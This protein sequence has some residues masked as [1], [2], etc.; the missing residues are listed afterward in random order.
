MTYESQPAIRWKKNLSPK[1]WDDTVASM[2]GHLLQTATWGQAKKTTFYLLDHYWIAY[3]KEQP[4]FLVRFEE[5]RY[6]GFKIAWIPKG[7]IF[8]HYDMSSIVFN[9]FL[10]QLKANGFLC[11]LTFPSKP[12]TTSQEKG[13]LPQTIWLDLRIGKECLWQQT[14]KK[15]RYGVRQAKQLG[16]LIAETKRADD[17][18]AFYALCQQLSRQKKFSLNTSLSFLQTLLTNAYSKQIESCLLLA[19]HDGHLQGGAFILRCGETVH[20][21]WGAVARHQMPTKVQVGEA[22]Q[23]AIIEWSLSRNCTRYDL[24]GVDKRK[25]PGVYQF[26]RKLRGQIITFPGMQIVPL[27]PLA[28]VGWYCFNTLQQI[29][30]HSLRLAGSDKVHL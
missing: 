9:D 4:I 21:L 14:Q 18:L 24:E 5:K 25:N 11:C 7:P 19:Q 17:V 6:A 30:P 3:Q 10:N 16:L 13:H 29:L 27:T 22:L 15:F 26:K 12:V 8:L 2:Q 20:Y 1:Q 23:W 28:K